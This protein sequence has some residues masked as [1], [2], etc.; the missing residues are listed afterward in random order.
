MQLPR[1]RG[2]I[3][4]EYGAHTVPRCICFQKR[5]GGAVERGLGDDRTPGF[6][7][8]QED[9]GDGSH[10][11]GE[12]HPPRDL[13]RSFIRILLEQVKRF[14]HGVFFRQQVQVGILDAG[15]VIAG[16]LAFEDRST[17]VRIRKG[18]GGGL[19]DGVD[20]RVGGVTRFT[21][22][23]NKRADPEH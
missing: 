20:V 11:G 18:K 1:H 19:I 8:G 12:H 5:M 3:I 7:A 13:L 10:A 9:A 16:F 6:A 17:K 22:V 4:Q 2:G 15:V 14:Q 23:V 21:G